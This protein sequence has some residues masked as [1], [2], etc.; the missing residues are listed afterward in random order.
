MV[1]ELEA[2]ADEVGVK[3]SLMG[4]PKRLL[5]L[6]LLAQGEMSVGAIAQAL[7]I[8]QSSLSQHLAKLRDGGLVTTR[9]EAQTIHYTLADD[10][11]RALMAA[12]YETFC[13]TD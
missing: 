5:I 12:L 13:A 1:K 4:N 7:E 11:T 10:Q 9:R 2:R 6:C 8:G 3:L